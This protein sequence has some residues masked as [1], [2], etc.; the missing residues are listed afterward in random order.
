[1]PAQRNPNAV[2]LPDSP[3]IARPPAPD[4]EKEAHREKML[5]AHWHGKRIR[6]HSKAEQDVILR[7]ATWEQTDEGRKEAADVARAAGR[8]VAEPGYIPATVTQRGPYIP[9]YGSNP[10]QQYGADRRLSRN[11]VDP[12]TAVRMAYEERDPNRAYHWAS[13]DIL[14]LADAMEGVI[15]DR[16]VVYGKNGSPVRFREMVL[17]SMPREAVEERRALELDA[18]NDSMR[19]LAPQKKHEALVLETGGGIPTQSINP[20]TGAVEDINF[21]VRPVAS[22]VGA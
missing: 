14:G 12:L 17:T 5:N 15:S 3:I 20:R 22:P 6:E 16:E 18:A 19:A 1:M 7:L 10:I 9:Q 8:F 2:E 11:P 13:P 21:G 4:A